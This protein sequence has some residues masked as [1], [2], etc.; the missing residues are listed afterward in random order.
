M[1]GETRLDYKVGDKS[2]A[3]QTIA[4][5]YGQTPEAIAGFL[6]GF[7]E[8]YVPEMLKELDIQ[9]PGAAQGEAPDKSHSG[10]TR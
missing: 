7:S 3:N 4:F 5:I 9:R 10:E 2:A 6:A 8:R 1:S